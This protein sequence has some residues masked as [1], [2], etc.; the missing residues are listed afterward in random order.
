MRMHPSIFDIFCCLLGSFMLFSVMAFAYFNES[1]EKT[2]PPIELAEGSDINSSGVTDYEPV[3]I[4]VKLRS[5][6]E[7]PSYFIENEEVLLSEI[8]ERLRALSPKEVSI[9]VDK[10]VQ[11]GLVI[12][13]MELCK[14]EHITNISFAYKV[15]PVRNFGRNFRSHQ[16]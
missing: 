13:L 12:S 8:S 5:K 4:S 11:F 6:D 16:N 7:K 3:T 14:Q 9:R 10:Q 15:N 1:P 2:L